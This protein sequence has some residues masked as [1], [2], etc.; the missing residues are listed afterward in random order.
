MSALTLAGVL[1]G[2]VLS[3]TSANILFIAFSHLFS[4]II[5]ESYVQTTSLKLFL[6]PHHQEKEDRDKKDS[7]QPIQT[8]FTRA[9]QEN[10]FPGPQILRLGWRTRFI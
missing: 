9:W 7:L 1:V 5:C 4:V 10:P 2:A 8:S 6:Q 3:T